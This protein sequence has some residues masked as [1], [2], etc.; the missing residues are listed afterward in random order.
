M[1]RCDCAMF[2]CWS[3]LPGWARR[4]GST[5]SLPTGFIPQEDQGYFMVIVQAPPGSSVAYTT[6]LADEGSSDYFANPHV[7]G[8]FPIIGFSFA[9]SASNAGMMFVN[10]TRPIKQQRKGLPTVDVMKDLGPKLQMLMFVPNGGF[11]EPLEPPA[12]SGVGSFG[13]FQ[14][15]LQDQGGNTLTDLDRVAHQIVGA[16]ASHKD[17]TYCLQPFPPTI[18]KS[19]SRSTARRPKRWAFRSRRSRLRSMFSWDRNTSTISTTTTAPI[20]C[21]FRPTSSSA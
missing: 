5:S 16:G 8:L 14:F 13:G 17:L 18:R 20:V 19:W 4:C 7:V 11:V 1:S 21:M 6:A 15:M 3:S 9:G 10:T 2:F 12:V